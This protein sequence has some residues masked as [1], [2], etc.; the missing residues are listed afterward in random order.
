MQINLVIF[1]S[2]DIRLIKEEIQRGLEALD[3]VEE[4]RDECSN[5]SY[6]KEVSDLKK[7]SRYCHYEK[8]CATLAEKSIE[9]QEFLSATQTLSDL[10][11][12]FPLS[13]TGLV[14]YKSLYWLRPN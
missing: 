13:A 3:K 2:E 12:I 4:L 8:E 9:T 7:C 6:K 1:Q 14:S 11:C 10:P 5:L